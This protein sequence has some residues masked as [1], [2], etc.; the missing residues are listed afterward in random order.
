MASV[1][2]GGS[3]WAPEELSPEGCPRLR[4]LPFTDRLRFPGSRD[5]V[6]LGK[7]LVRTPSRIGLSEVQAA[8]LDL[9]TS[10]RH[11]PSARGER[12]DG[13]FT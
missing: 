7:T 11:L 9:Q 10:G 3:P 5:M 1:L 6:P 13:L 12:P 4:R 8:R 2:W